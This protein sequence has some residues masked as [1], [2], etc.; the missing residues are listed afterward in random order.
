MA[1]VHDEHAFGGQPIRIDRYLTD[2]RG[3]I[4]E[5]IQKGIRSEAFD[6]ELSSDDIE[7]LSDFARIFGDLNDQGIY[8]GSERSGSQDDFHMDKPRPHQPYDFKELL[9]TKSG[10]LNVNIATELFDWAE[11]LM[12]PIGGMDKIIDAFMENIHSRVSLNSIVQKIHLAED[13]VTVQYQ[14]NTVKYIL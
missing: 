4:A 7:K 10:W 11:P 8:E 5:L 13:D 12:E 9:K 2:E 14:K 6:A 3:F 1:Y